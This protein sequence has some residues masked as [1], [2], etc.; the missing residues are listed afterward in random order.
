[1]SFLYPQ[2]ISI[3]RLS[4]LTQTADGAAQTMATVATNVPASI[5][6]KRD[7]GFSAPLGFQAS[8]NSSAPLPEWIIFLQ[9]GN[10]SFTPQDGDYVTDGQ[11]TWKAVAAVF[12]PLGWRLFCT[13]YAPDA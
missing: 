5:Q 10:T 13:P 9:P 7:K 4:A 12:S 11:R 8:S 6:F 2:T 3:N 1:M